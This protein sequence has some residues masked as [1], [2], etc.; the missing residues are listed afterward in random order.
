MQ[1]TITPSRQARNSRRAA[2]LRLTS[3]TR[4]AAMR[5]PIVSIALLVIIKVVV[6]LV[7]GSVSV[8]SDAVHSLADLVVSVVQLISV[9]LAARPA[10]DNHAY[11]HGK[12]ENLSAGL[13]AIII[14]AT[15]AFVVS[16]AIARLIVPVARIE[17]VDVGII[18]MFA[19]A[20]LSV[21]L[22]VR[23]MA[24]GKQEQSPALLAQA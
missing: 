13:V 15:G 23:L 21:V 7:S 17:H 16:Q 10:D 6:W 18:V 22:S 5:V 3:D 2:A 4:V 9:R 19:S 11:G 20:L 14:V 12:F 24:V 8:L 1:P